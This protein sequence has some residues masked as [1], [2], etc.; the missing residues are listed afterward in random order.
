MMLARGR[1]APTSAPNTAETIA[2]TT[3]HVDPDRSVRHGRIAAT[4]RVESAAPSSLFSHDTHCPPPFR[5]PEIHARSSFR[6]ARGPW[7][8]APRARSGLPATISFARRGTAGG[9]RFFPPCRMMTGPRL[10]TQVSLFQAARSIQARMASRSAAC[11]VI[12]RFLAR[13]SRTRQTSSG[14]RTDR[15]DVPPT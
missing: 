4:D 13:A 8:S 14:K 1:T 7:R 12:P 5:R 11:S 6:T 3:G 9:L 2:N 10:E 15:G